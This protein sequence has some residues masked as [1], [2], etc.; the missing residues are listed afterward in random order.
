MSEP[1][2]LDDLEPDFRRAGVDAGEALRLFV[3]RN[4]PFGLQVAPGEPINIELNLSVLQRILRSLP[5]GAGTE[6]F[7]DAWAAEG[8]LWWRDG[9]GARGTPP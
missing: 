1:R 8:R 7:V 2:T 3:N 6:K 9:P 4:N 5:D